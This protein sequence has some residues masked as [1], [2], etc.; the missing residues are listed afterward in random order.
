MSKIYFCDKCN[1]EIKTGDLMYGKSR[2]HVNCEHPQDNKFYPVYYRDQEKS[3]WGMLNET[4]SSEQI[5]KII[6]YKTIE[7]PSNYHVHRR[8]II[9]K[10]KKTDL[11][12]WIREVIETSETIVYSDVKSLLDFILTYENCIIYKKDFDYILEVKLK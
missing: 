1:K 5:T 12:C 7:S 2:K 9:E 4:I 6:I 8:V 3:R 11:K 10:W